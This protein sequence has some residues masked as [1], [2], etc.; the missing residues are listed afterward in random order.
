MKTAYR[1][2][3]LIAIDGKIDENTTLGKLLD[4]IP[5]NLITMDFKKVTLKGKYKELLE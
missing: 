1:L 3:L 2:D 5:V 4:I